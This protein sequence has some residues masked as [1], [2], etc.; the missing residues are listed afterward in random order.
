MYL[1]PILIVFLDIFTARKLSDLWDVSEERTPST[2]SA[3]SFEGLEMSAKQST[4]H[5]PQLSEQ[6]Q[7]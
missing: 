1:L 6:A 2:C 5:M 3:E 4:P 7:H